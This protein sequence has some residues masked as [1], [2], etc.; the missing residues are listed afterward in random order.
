MTASPQ[1]FP[2]PPDG[3]DDLLVEFLA[4]V[5]DIDDPLP[6]L[7]AAASFDDWPAA[8]A[9]LVARAG[10]TARQRRF[11]QERRFAQALATA[12]PAVTTDS[13]P[14]FVNQRIS[15][16]PVDVLRAGGGEDLCYLKIN[17][18]FWEQLYAIFGVNDPARMRI[19]DPDLFRRRYVESGFL[20]ALA[21]AIG[22]VARAERERLA[23][24]GIRFGVSLASGTHD[25]SDVL[26]GFATRE[27]REQKIVMGAAIGLASWWEAFF[28]GSRPDFCDGSFPKQGLL[29]GRL[30]ETLLEA[31]GDAARI[32]FVVPPHLAGIRLLGTPLPQETVLVPAETVHESWAAGLA[33]V[34]SH[35]MGRLAGEGR[36]VLITQ[37]AVFSALLGCFL[38][39]ARRRLLP[40]EA[41]LHFF[42]LGQAL[43]VAAPAAGGP[44]SRRHAAGA[45]SLFQIDPR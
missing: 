32:V 37:S 13:L 22:L 39:D 31:A 3:F 41:R 12:A 19:R 1:P 15:V 40:R 43:D 5:L 38:A 35:V 14:A 28:P 29:S 18:G 26:A 8:T 27:P 24:P 42:D 4:T 36:V 23:F 20:E 33:A 9:A 30:R 34:G 44:W 2:P 11:D 21:A 17:H 45:E 25:H 16:R 7:P 10:P 6:A